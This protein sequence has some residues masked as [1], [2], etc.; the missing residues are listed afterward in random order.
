MSRD[1]LHSKQCHSDQWGKGLVNLG[2]ACWFKNWQFRNM[3]TFFLFFHKRQG[4]KHS[5]A[6][7]FCF[8][9]D[10]VNC[11][12]IR[13]ILSRFFFFLD[14]LLCFPRKQIRFSLYLKNGLKVDSRQCMKAWFSYT[15]EES[16]F[17]E[18]ERLA[19]KILE[20]AYLRTVCSLLLCVD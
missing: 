20:R 14:E 11:N 7:L 1:T 9:C 19:S 18:G 3:D 5:L 16:V 15:P 10:I 2:L 17:W 8:K 12:M 6:F 4:I 13:R